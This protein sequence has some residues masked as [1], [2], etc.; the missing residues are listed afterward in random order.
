MEERH[1]V[2]LWYYQE[3]LASVGEA[4]GQEEAGVVEQDR[5]SGPGVAQ[6]VR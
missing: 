5:E 6:H 4:A 3:V 1:R 2:L